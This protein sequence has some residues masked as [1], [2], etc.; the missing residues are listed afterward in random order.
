MQ[1]VVN[2]QGH[3]HC[4]Y[5]EAIDLSTLG[6]LSI[7]RASFVEPDAA[8]HWTADLSLVDGPVLGPFDQRTE[9]LAAEQTWLEMHWLSCG[10][11]GS[12]GQAHRPA[13]ESEG[14][15]KS[16]LHVTQEEFHT[17][18]AALRFYQDR[19]SADQASALEWFQGIAT[20]LGAVDALD[21]KAIDALCQRLNTEPV[22][23][24]RPCD[25]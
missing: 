6:L 13:G 18:L 24:H 17:I 7:A 9:A 14:R 16:T 11:T 21:A 1:L 4:L 19:V 2:R 25:P 20:N 10:Q 5:G 22:D 23:T 8:G 12:L 3:I 15:T